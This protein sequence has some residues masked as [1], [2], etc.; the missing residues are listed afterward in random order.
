M[1]GG[2]G[3]SW[4]SPV[5]D[6]RNDRN[7][8]ESWR[9]LSLRKRLAQNPYSATLSGVAGMYTPPFQYCFAEVSWNVMCNSGAPSCW[10]ARMFDLA[11][12]SRWWKK[13][14]K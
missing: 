14:P 12:T 11:H 13:V 10:F 7:Q 2:Y 9:D 1:L 5:G 3:S 6:F 4:A 8:R